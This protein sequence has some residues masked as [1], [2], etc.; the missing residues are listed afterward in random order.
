MREIKFKYIMKHQISGKLFTVY[1]TIEELENG[2]RKLWELIKVGYQIYKKL[3]FT[4]LR[5]LD[6]KEI[7][8]EDSVRFSPVFK[9]IWKGNIIWGRY[10]KW[11][12]DCSGDDG[13]VWDFS[14]R[15]IYE[16]VGNKIENIEVIGNIYE[17]PEL[18][19][20]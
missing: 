18:K 9:H 14:T 5:D 10:G 12:V 7:Y 11:L 4:G 6:K 16:E 13:G 2:A 19:E 17:N 1:Q 8:E 20:K 3:Q 15:T